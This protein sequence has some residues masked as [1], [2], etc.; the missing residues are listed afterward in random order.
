MKKVVSV[1]VLFLLSF[2]FILVGCSNGLVMPAKTAQ[3]KGNGSFVVQK[4]EYIYFANAYTGYST[5]AEE[6][7]NSD[8]QFA[9]YRV[10]VSDS[11]NSRI[12]FDEDGYALGVEKIVSKINGFENSG[13]YIVGDYLYFAS[14]NVHKTNRNE[15]RFDLVTIF[16]V[17]LDGSS[18]C[19]LYTT[20]DYTNGDWSVLEINEKAYLLTVENENIVRQEV[21]DGKISNKTVLA[22]DVVSAVLVDE[23]TSDFDEYI[24]Y[25]TERTDEEVELGFSGNILKKVN[26]ETGVITTDANPFGQTIT[27]L[28]QENSKLFYTLK[29]TNSALKLY[30]KSWQEADKKLAEWTDATNLFFMGSDAQNNQRP[31]I[32]NSQSKLVMQN[33]DSMEVTILVDEDVKPLFV[34]GDY[35]YYSTAEGISRISYIDKTEQ[36]VLTATFQDDVVDFDGRYIYVFATLETDTTG[37][38]YLQRLDTYSLVQN[39]QESLKVVG[40]VLEDDKAQEE[41]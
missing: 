5:L 29:T 33:F 16:S 35:V 14:P 41:E 26:I 37:T 12:T 18:L 17:K 34:C 27:I 32:Y 15:N 24:Y 30:V 1:L 4:G 36:V 23:V 19:E 21:K 9:L 38:Q 25:T 11:T 10:K 2:A 31:F 28:K 39:P 20:V 8:A 22:D 13:L 6:V 3:I 40:Y 7:S